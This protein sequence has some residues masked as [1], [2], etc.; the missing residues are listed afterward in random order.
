MNAQC[1][2]YTD[3]GVICGKPATAIDPVRGCTVCNEHRPKEK[4][5]ERVGELQST[6]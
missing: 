3:T 5:D 4:G 2:A 1:W 6:P